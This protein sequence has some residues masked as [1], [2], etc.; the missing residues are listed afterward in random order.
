VK[1]SGPKQ[2]LTWFD[3]PAELNLFG[4]EI[5]AMGD[6]VLGNVKSGGYGYT[7][8]R[9]LCCAYV[10][11]SE[12]AHPEYAIEVMGTRYPARRHGKAPYD[13]ERKAILA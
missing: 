10:A 8:G 12:P 9:N 4:G 3:A 2:K 7:V 13:P 5:V 11:A 1:T 6:R